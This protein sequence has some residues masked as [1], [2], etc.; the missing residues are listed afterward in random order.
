[1]ST[2]EP[3]PN[4]LWMPG[5]YRAMVVMQGVSGLPEDRYITTWH[6]EDVNTDVL[7]P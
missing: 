2:T 5:V 3:Q 6:F 4:A 1:M 7:Q